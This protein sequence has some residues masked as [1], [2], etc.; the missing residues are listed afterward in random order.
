LAYRLATIHNVHFLLELMRQV[1]LSIE[2]GHFH[3][4]KTEFLSRYPIIPHAVRAAHR[5]KR[6]ARRS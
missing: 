3:T 2:A 1:R 6:K 5:A 4:F